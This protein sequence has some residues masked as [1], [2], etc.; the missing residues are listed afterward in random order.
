[1]AIEK[2]LFNF[3]DYFKNPIAEFCVKQNPIIK[4]YTLDDLN[5]YLDK[6]PYT[7][8][9]LKIDRKVSIGNEFRLYL[10]SISDEFFYLDSDCFI[11][12][13]IMNE[14][15]SIKN[16]VAVHKN[17]H[18]EVGTFLHC[19]KNN[20]FVNF[21]LNKYHE[22][23]S[24]KECPHELQVFS[25][26]PFELHDGYFG[27]TQLYKIDKN[28]KH[29]YLNSLK[30]FHKRNPD[31]DKIYYTYKHS[32]KSDFK[33][34]WMFNTDEENYIRTCNFNKTTFWHFDT[35]NYPY[36]DQGTLEDLFKAQMNYLYQKDMKYIEV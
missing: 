5:E 6:L 36:I 31:I 28:I 16:C 19:Q 24:Q 21:Y 7:Q 13:N 9:M 32:G 15:D 26:N 1:M 35:C 11:P 25:K 17:N 27:D 4:V 14:L 23:A 34:I 2:T 8:K 10:A 33:D 22:I 29:F 30:A 18:I 12:Q 20:R 3:Y